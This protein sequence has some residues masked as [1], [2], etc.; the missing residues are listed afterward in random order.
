MTKA[1][2]D[3]EL[4]VEEVVTGAAEEV[5]VDVLMLVE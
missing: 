2:E 4:L 3:V 5:D 1:E